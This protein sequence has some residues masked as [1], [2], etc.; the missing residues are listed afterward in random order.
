MITATATCL[1]IKPVRSILKYFN[2]TKCFVPHQDCI[3]QNYLSYFSFNEGDNEIDVNPPKYRVISEDHSSLSSPEQLHYPQSDVSL[4]QSGNFLENSDSE[5]S[6]VKLI[7][8]T[9]TGRGATTD[10][11]E[12]ELWLFLLLSRLHLVK[13]GEATEEFFMFFKFSLISPASTAGCAAGVL[14]SNL[15]ITHR[16]K[17]ACSRVT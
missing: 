2:A 11:R 15:V 16:T 9:V 7:L 1:L 4:P 12:L 14:G 3:E 5:F 10:G 13:D 8:G 17:L 6:S